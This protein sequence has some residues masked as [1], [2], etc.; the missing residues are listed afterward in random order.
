MLQIYVDALPLKS[1]VRFRYGITSHSSVNW[2][3]SQERV[4]FEKYVKT[5]FTHKVRY[6]TQI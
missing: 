6:A 3:I 4:L 1:A 2:D 5:K